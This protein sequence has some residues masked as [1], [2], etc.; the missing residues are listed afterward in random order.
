MAIRRAN[1]EDINTIISLLNQLGYQGTEEFME[2]KLQRLINHLDEELVVW[3]ESNQVVALMSIHFIPQLALEGD[4]ARISYFSVDNTVRSN[5]IGKLLEEYCTG[6]AK[7]RK[8]DRIEVH[9]HQRR[10]DAHRFY[11]RQGYEEVPKYL[12]KSLVKNNN[13]NI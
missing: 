13:F 5:G 10:K 12:M 8:C 9:C 3:E 7:D 6:L 11:F 4:F 2:G 1:S